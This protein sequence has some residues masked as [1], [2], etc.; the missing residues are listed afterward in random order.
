M[1]TT[2]TITATNLDERIKLLES[3]FI[4]LI[5]NRLGIVIRS[6]QIYN[7]TKTIHE[8]CEKFHCSADEYLVLLHDSPNQSPILNHLIN[9]ITVGETY[10]FRDKQQMELLKNDLLPK[11]IQEKRNQHN[12][13]IRI[14]S[15][16]CASG[17]EI[18]TIAMMLLE[19]IPDIEHWT[20]RLLATD[21]NTDVLQ[22]GISGVYSEWSMRSI[23]EYFKSTYFQ[24]KGKEYILHN[25]V[26]DLVTFDYLNLNDDNYPSVFNG[27]NAQDLILCR[28]VLIYFDIESS[29]RLMKRLNHSLTKGGYLLLGASDPLNISGIDYTFHHNKGLLLSKPY[30]DS[31]VVYTLPTINPAIVVVSKNPDT[32]SHIKIAKPKIH[33][34]ESH[35]SKT[36]S[37]KAI[38]FANNGLLEEALKTCEQGFKCEPTNK[39][40]YFIHAL[41]LLEMNR[42]NEA[43]TSFRKALF[44]D[45]QF[46]AGHF[47]LGLLLIRKKQNSVG[48]KY[49][50]NALKIAETKNLDEPVMGSPGLCY[51]KF[52]DILRNEI[53]LYTTPGVT[54][55]P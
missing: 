21:I 37:D 25:K 43:E 27:T 34:K 13:S 28:N 55:E 17:E 40:N 47:Q 41:T 1:R 24:K 11:I 26:C 8:A 23:N 29:Q 16:G 19:L 46:V 39:L 10:F 38:E 45:N 50:N 32:V 6:H 48:L 2:P 5:K 30:E 42:Y 52:V 35:S 36:L 31:K 33:K 18:Y 44:L 9:G 3:K 12:L 20:I 14:W 51:Q 49:L 15:A 7:L 4:E 53:T 54:N 22:K